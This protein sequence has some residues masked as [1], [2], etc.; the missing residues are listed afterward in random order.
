MDIKL[1]IGTRGNDPCVTTT[2]MPITAVMIATPHSC[3][4]TSSGA[5]HDTKRSSVMTNTGTILLHIIRGVP[6]PI[7]AVGSGSIWVAADGKTTAG[8]GMGLETGIA[9][10]GETAAGIAE[11][12]RGDGSI[13]DAT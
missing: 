3:S 7:S 9:A 4:V 1:A 6:C 12:S 8:I 5:E 11:I 13:A 2:G 10:G